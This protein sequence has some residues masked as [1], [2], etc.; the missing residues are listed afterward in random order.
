ML[1]AIFYAHSFFVYK[2][3]VL[4]YTHR[5]S[6]QVDCVWNVMAH[7]Q[8]PDFVF[9]RNGRVNLNRR[10]CQFSRLLAAKVCTSAAVMLDT[11][12][13][14]VEWTVL[15]THSIRQFHLHFPSPCAIAFQLESNSRWQVHCLPPVALPRLSGGPFTILSYGRKQFN[16]CWTFKVNPMCLSAEHVFCTTFYNSCLEKVKPL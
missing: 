4:W 15:A 16:P 7:S 3:E 1:I 14:E 11:T 10:G 6:N 13:S 5:E 2:T 12:C 8:K 9:R